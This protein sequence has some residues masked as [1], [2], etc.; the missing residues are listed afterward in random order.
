LGPGEVLIAGVADG[1]GRSC[2]AWAMRLARAC[3][4]TA[5]SPSQ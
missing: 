1:S 5:E 3:S 4:R 2:W